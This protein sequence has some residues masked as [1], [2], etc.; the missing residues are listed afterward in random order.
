MSAAYLN[1]SGRQQ[2]VG[3]IEAQRV[4]GGLQRSATTTDEAW[5]AFVTLAASA[6]WKSAACRAFVVELAKRAAA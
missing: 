6:G 2:A 3:A 5:L 4:I 1:D